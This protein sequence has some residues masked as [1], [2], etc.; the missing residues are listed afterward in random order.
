MNL[1]QISEALKGVPKQF[2]VQEATQP[3][4][5]YPQYMIVAELSEFC[6][7]TKTQLT[8]LQP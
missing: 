3:S 5:R 2:L 7:F 1:L 4:G 6:F 8:P